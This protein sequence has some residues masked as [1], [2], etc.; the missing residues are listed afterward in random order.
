M[1]YPLSL[2]AVKTTRLN[3]SCSFDENTINK[4]QFCLYKTEEYE[5]C[6]GSK[7]IGFITTRY[8]NKLAN[9]EKD[10]KKEYSK[11]GVLIDKH[12]DIK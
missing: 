6:K 4:L 5:Y 2:F 9:S 11:S 3:L 12:M 1:Y 8:I 7:T 10:N